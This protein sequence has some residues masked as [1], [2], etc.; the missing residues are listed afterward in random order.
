MARTAVLRVD[1]A[2]LVEV[3]QGFGAAD[4]YSALGLQLTGT[5]TATV[6]F[7]AS[8][9]N[10][11]TWV[12]VLGQPVAADGTL[13]TAASSATAADQWIFTLGGFS[14]FR[15]RVDAYTSGAIEVAIAKSDGPS[16]GSGG[17]AISTGTGADQIQG[18][19]ANDAADAGNPVK[20]GGVALS[21]APSA[22]TTGDRVN[23]M[24]SLTGALTVAGVSALAAAAVSNPLLF[25]DLAGAPRSLAVAPT[26]VGSAGT[27]PSNST[28]T[29][30]ENDRVIKSSA[31]TLYGLTV[32]NN[33][34]AA[35][36]IQLHDATAAPADTTVP[37]LVFEIAPQS[38]RSLD[39]GIYG[40][41][42]A[43]GI[44]VCNSTT[45]VTKTL[46]ADDCL[47]DAQFL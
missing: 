43:V 2:T 38:A 42:F 6:A 40:R 47:F 46:G 1:E 25:T 13:G 19:V 15:A 39:L 16:Y 21:I 9:D 33:N 11:T 31:G 3:L 29:A 37:G 20:I 23:A 28:S 27:S 30:Q 7:E 5:F 12:A 14:H 36:W 10:G 45:D 32:Y 22:V 34:V 4:S 18:N 8:I 44:Y 35:Q 24:F 41:R 26:P 17:G